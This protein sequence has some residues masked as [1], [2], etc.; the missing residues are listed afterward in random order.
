MI[1]LRMIG[2]ALGEMF[3]AAFGAL[4]DRFFPQKTVGEQKQEDRADSDEKALKVNEAMQKADELSPA[5]LSD[6]ETILRKG[7][8]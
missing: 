2:A 3:S 1:F 4:M 8:G 5:T 6:A 7:E